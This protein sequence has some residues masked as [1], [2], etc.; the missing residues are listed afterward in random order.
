MSKSP[1]GK[2]KTGALHRQLGYKQDERI[3]LGLMKDISKA[4]VGTK[5]RGFSVTPLLKRRVNFALNSRS[6]RR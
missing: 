5:V 6:W 3:P 1:F 4:N 2:I